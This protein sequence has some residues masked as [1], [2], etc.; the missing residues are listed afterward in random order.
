VLQP[1]RQQSSILSVITTTDQ[2]NQYRQQ[3]NSII[4]SDVIG[5]EKT[6]RD[7]N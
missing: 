1:R 2:T 3:C 7:V 6:D 4:L 5:R